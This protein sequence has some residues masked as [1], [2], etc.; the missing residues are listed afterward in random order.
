MMVKKSG[1]TVFG[2][3]TSSEKSDEYGNTKAV[4]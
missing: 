1:T 4:D 3:V 2:A